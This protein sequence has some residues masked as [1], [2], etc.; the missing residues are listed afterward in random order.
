M[1]WMTDGKSITFFLL[2]EVKRM[3]RIRDPQL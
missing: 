3:G 2:C 1:A